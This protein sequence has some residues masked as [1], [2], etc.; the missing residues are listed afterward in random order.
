MPRPPETRLV[1]LV[2]VN[3]Y[4]RVIVFVAAILIAIRLLFPSDIGTTLLNALGIAAMAVGL[5]FLPPSRRTYIA[6]STVALAALRLLVPVQGAP[7]ITLIHS[8]LILTLGL[9][10][11]FRVAERR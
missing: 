5:Y 6:L 3:G 1:R 11:F 10:L 4:Q 8:V 9:V 7:T 2:P